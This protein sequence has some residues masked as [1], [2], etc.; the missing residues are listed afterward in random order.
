MR[1]SGL[2]HMAS[3]VAQP[4][5][6]ELEE[7]FDMEGGDSQSVDVLLDA[8]VRE[9]GKGVDT[10]FGNALIFGEDGEGVIGGEFLYKQP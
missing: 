4:I 2:L 3:R 7:S 9:Y 5:L 10:N 8:L 1:L 6:K